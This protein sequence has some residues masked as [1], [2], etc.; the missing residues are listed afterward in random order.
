MK[1]FIFTS[2][3]DPRAARLRAALIE[4]YDSRYGNFYDEEGAKAELDRYPAEDFS[5]PRGNFL[6]LIDGEE[7]IGVGALKFY[8]ET[9]AELNRIWIDNCY[10][11]QGLDALIL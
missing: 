8:D 1:Q 2:L 10:L 11:R 4:E 9:T 6:L 5:P 3:K 7:T